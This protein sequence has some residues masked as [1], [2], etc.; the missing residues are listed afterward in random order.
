MAYGYL[1]F[2]ILAALFWAIGNVI[3][4]TVLTD[5]VT[6]PVVVTFFTGVFGALFALI[7]LPLGYV[8]IPST[9]VL[10]ISILLGIVYMA[11]IYFYMKGMTLEEVSR[12]IPIMN[13]S[14]V[15]V[16]ILGAIFLNEVFT[17]QKYLGMFLAITGSVMVASKR[18]GK[19]FFHLEANK[20]YWLIFTGTFIFAAYAV[21]IRWIL[22]FSDFWNIFFWSRM[23]GLIPVGFFLLH[24][25]TREQVI[26]VVNSIRESKVE[27]MAI[28]ELMNDLGV[29]S[30]TVALGLGAAALVQTAAS[31]QPLFVLIFVGTLNYVWNKDLGDDL[32]R[33]AVAVKTISA[34]MIIIGIY[35]IK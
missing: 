4:K 7:L 13:I 19:K 1:A 9:F 32:S 24:Q 30:Q 33:K 27:Y 10:G 26:S 18:F 31:I 22:N 16:V 6:N 2:A 35:L 25:N 5:Y 3:D 28:S 12:V 17:L 29:L 14:P 23:G 8:Q 11:P 34:I 21:S 20:A 15:F